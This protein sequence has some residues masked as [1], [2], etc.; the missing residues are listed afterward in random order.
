MKIQTWLDQTKKKLVDAEIPSA[1][2]DS[3]LILE[4]MLGVTREWILAHNQAVLKADVL[5]K[6]NKKVLQRLDHIPLAYIISSKE[7]Y[8]RIFFVDN[9]VLIPRPESEAMIGLLK[10]LTNTDASASLTILDVGTGSGCLAITA[11]LELPEATVIATD[12]SAEALA[13]AKQ[14]ANLL[15]APVQ[16]YKADLLNVPPAIKPDVMLA[17]LP[18]VPDSLV[19]SEEITKEPG[20]AL[21]SGKDGLAHYRRFW[22][23]VSSLRYKLPKHIVTESLKEQHTTMLQLAKQAG[24]SLKDTKDLIQHFQ[25]I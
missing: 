1:R 21:F 18:Y 22:Q 20:I 19:T 9:S 6:L 5:E 25:L 16:F 10:E 15:E 4:N 13:V 17:N 2:L 11:Q 7:F 23:Q 14:N 24:Y 12:I 8:G 3:F